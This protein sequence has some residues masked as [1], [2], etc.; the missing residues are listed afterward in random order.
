MQVDMDD[1]IHVRFY[2]EMVDKLLEIDYEMYSPF[3]VEEK[4]VCILYVEWLKAL[5]GTPTLKLAWLFGSW[6]KN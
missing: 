2:R 5:Y 4:D 6:R 3:M 1:L